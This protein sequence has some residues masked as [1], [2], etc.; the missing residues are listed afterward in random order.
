VG[1]A[2][3]GGDFYGRW[4]TLVVGGPDDSGS[5]VGRFIPTTSVEQYSATLAQW[6]GLE[7]AELSLVFPNVGRFASANLGFLA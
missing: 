5:D 1:G 4:P 3:K 6:F 7:A 2:V